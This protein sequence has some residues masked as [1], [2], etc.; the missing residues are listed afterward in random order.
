[1]TLFFLDSYLFKISGSSVAR[2][3]VSLP[4]E[5]LRLLEDE[6]AVQRD[7]AVYLER[8][9]PT[10]PI[11]SKLRLQKELTLDRPADTLLL[12]LVLRLLCRTLDPVPDAHAVAVFY[13][14][15]KHCAAALEAAGLVSLRRL[16]AC[17]LLAHHELAY[18]LFPAAYMSVG[19]C[20]RLG[21]M[22]GLHSGRE[23]VRMPRPPLSMIACEEYHRVWWATFVLDRYVNIGL[24]DRRFACRRANPDEHLPMDETAWEEG[25]STVRPSLAVSSHAIVAA[26]PFAR[27]C[28][29]AHLL[30]R[31]LSHTNDRQPVSHDDYQ[32]YYQEAMQLL[33]ILKAL[34]AALLQELQEAVG[35]D[36]VSVST[37]PPPAAIAL[38]PGFALC[39]AAQLCFM[40]MHGCVEVDNVRAAGLAIQLETQAA[41]IASAKEIIG[42]VAAFA[43]LV[44]QALQAPDGPVVSPLV[45]NCFYQTAKNLVLYYQES[46]REDLN[47]A[48]QEI[49]RVLADLG[50]LWPVANDSL[51]ILDLECLRSMECSM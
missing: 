19:A 37:T 28:Q 31:V 26:P 36:V 10:F 17:L 38:L 22:M 3:T 32:A 20:A 6:A 45:V 30:S 4:P 18:G 21:Q 49:K 27:T 51:A 48:L 12:L 40:D 15:A 11:I 44:R 42:P 25:E 8:V 24:D 46:G 47:E 39:V 2:P 29:A 14:S 50:K 43:R 34:T 13:G 41:A 35:G 33:P 16:Q 9:H 23:A 5:G 7:V 1:M